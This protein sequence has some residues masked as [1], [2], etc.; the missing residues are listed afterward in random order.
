MQRENARETEGEE[1]LVDCFSDMLICGL[2]LN[3]GR[4]TCLR[5]GHTAAPF[6]TITRHDAP[7]V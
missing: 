1:K 2:C 6:R 5:S 4:Q 3:D 7:P